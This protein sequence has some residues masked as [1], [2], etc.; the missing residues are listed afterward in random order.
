MSNTFPYTKFTQQLTHW[1]ALAQRDL[2]WRA[3]ENARDPYRILVSEVMLQQTTV[4]AVIPFY[5]RFLAR[6]PD[7]ST[8]ALAEIDE[9]LPLWAGLGY[10]SRA[11]NL[12]AAAQVIQAKHEGKFPQVFAEVLALPGV[13][14]Y[15]AGAVC[16]IAFDQKTPI[17]D[18]NIMRVLA[19]VLC[20]EGDIKNSANQKR[21]WQE[22]ATLVEASAHP[23]QFNPAMMELGA[24]ICTP[25]KPDCEQCPVSKF[26]SAFQSNRQHELPQFSPK[27]PKTQLRDLCIFIGNDR[28]VLLRQR[29]AQNTVRNW[30]HGMWELPRTTVKEGEN[31]TQAIDRLLQ[32]SQIEGRIG[33]QLKALKHTVTIHAITLECYEITTAQKSFSDAEFFE[34]DETQQ[35][36][37]PSTMKKL[38]QWLERHHLHSK[39]LELL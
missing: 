9:V 39:Q 19:R 30:W 7:V 29:T 35:L 28:E 16:S 12:H 37:I 25:K 38:L 13:G 10:Y 3:V 4:A 24:L 14:P 33:G 27:K 36:A 15:T 26:C 21:L 20:L 22:A 23:A 5:Q 31:T 32:E 18:A 1:F 6:F 2:P 34:W 17:V 8:L 11:R